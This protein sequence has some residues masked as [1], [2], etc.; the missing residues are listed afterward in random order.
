MESLATTVLPE[1]GSRL[2]EPR[3]ENPD[4][5]SRTSSWRVDGTSLDDDDTRRRAV[6]PDGMTCAERDDVDDDV[7]ADVAELDLA[8]CLAEA[9]PTVCELVGPLLGDDDAD[10]GDD[11]MVRD[12]PLSEAA[13]GAAATL[14][15]AF[16]TPLVDRE[17]FGG[18]VLDT[19]LLLPLI[20]A[21]TCL[22]GTATLLTA[23]CCRLRS[24]APP[25]PPA[26]ALL[27]AT[28]D[29]DT[30]GDGDVLRAFA[31]FAAGAFIL[32]QPYMVLTVPKSEVLSV[33]EVPIR[34]VYLGSTASMVMR[35][36]WL[37][38]A[39]LP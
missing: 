6:R 1:P 33:L 13:V 29:A 30:A 18:P 16:T 2:D 11:A 31:A 39:V 22:A 37:A 4:G 15:I 12:G 17:A 28:T 25:A 36:G 24:T 34:L 27:P 35:P 8:G 5:V 38:N 23:G 20:E 3:S 19:L 26:A 10:D 14:E 7:L 21:T 32:V 9:P